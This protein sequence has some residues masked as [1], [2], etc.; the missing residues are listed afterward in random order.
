MIPFED[1][2]DYRV[3]RNDWPYGL[4]SEIIHIVV[5]SRTIIPTDPET[6]DLTPSSR[7]IVARFIHR[8]FARD[9]GPD[10]TEKVMWFKNWVALQS[11]R[12]LEHVHVMVRGVD[13]KTILKWTEERPCHKAE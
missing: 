13:E 8:Y 4:D 6:G 2:S 12:A 11:V 3:L 9:L 7:R 10:G 1:P 5:W